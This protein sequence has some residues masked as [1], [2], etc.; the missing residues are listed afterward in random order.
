MNERNDRQ[1]AN[2]ARRALGADRVIN[3]SSGR[4]RGPFDLLHQCKELIRLLEEDARWRGVIVLAT[5]PLTFD[6]T[7]FLVTTVKHV[8]VEYLEENCDDI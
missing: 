6:A 4:L 2:R 7:S 3:L 1:L 8:C 5:E